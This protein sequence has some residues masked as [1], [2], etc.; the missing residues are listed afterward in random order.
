[1]LTAAEAERRRSA[2]RAEYA[3]RVEAC[4]TRY[5]VEAEAILRARKHL[6]PLSKIIRAREL[7][8]DIYLRETAELSAISAEQTERLREVDADAPPI[9]LVEGATPRPGTSSSGSDTGEY[10]SELRSRACRGLAVSTGV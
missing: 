9:A 4:Q 2:I 8:R 6:T 3:R 10:F 1:M 5:R 7:L